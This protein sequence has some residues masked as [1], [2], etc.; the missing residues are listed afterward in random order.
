MHHQGSKAGICSGQRPFWSNDVDARCFSHQVRM[1][2]TV[3][4]ETCVGETMKQPTFADFCWSI[5]CWEGWTKSA[6]VE[7]GPTP[8][9]VDTRID[10][11]IG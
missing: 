11:M 8:R 10:D 6:A 5:F 7:Q 4:W 1:F 9:K 3:L 2:G